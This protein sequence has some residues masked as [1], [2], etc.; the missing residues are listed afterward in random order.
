MTTMALNKAF[1][2]CDIY[3]S[4]LTSTD[5]DITFS[6]VAG[7][8]QKTITF[9]QFHK[10]LDTLE[11]TKT[12]FCRAAAVQKL[13]T[14]LITYK[15]RPSLRETAADVRTLCS[16]VEFLGGG[17]EPQ[18][19]AGTLLAADV[20]ESSSSASWLPTGTAPQQA[21]SPSVLMATDSPP[22]ASKA[23]AHKTGKLKPNVGAASAVFGDEASRLAFAVEAIK[24][25]D[26]AALQVS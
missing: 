22:V 10:L 7:R 4:D 1:K 16:A 23:R 17:S 19:D 5:T 18:P 15:G 20:R 11:T 24:S 6:K 3:T 21:G 12:G 9:E 2:C 26:T 14:G 13:A 25:G 8:G